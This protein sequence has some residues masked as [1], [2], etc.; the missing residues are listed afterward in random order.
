MAKSPTSGFSLLRTALLGATALV[1]LNPV[2]AEAR[3]GVTSA[4]DG[5]PKG[6]PP[7][8]AERVLRIGIDVQA[9]E[10][11][12]TGAN[13][14]A[15]LVFLDGTALTVGPNARLTVDK[16]V[17]DPATKTGDLA[18]TASK[19]VFRLVG[20]KISKNNPIAITTPSSTIGIRG[21]VVWFSVTDGQ[22]TSNFVFGDKMTVTGQG[23]T[24]TATRPGFQVTSAL[25]LPP[26]TPRV[27]PP[28]GLSA[29][30]G[31]LEGTGS[32]SGG[33]GGDADGGAAGFGAGNSGSGPK[34]AGAP[35]PSMP[36]PSVTKPTDATPPVTPPVPTLVL[37]TRT[38][39]I[40]NSSTGGTDTSLKGFVGGLVEQTVPNQPVSSRILFSG[41]SP[42]DVKIQTNAATNRVE[43]TIVVP[44]LN[45][46]GAILTYQLGGLSN[47]SGVSSLFVDDKTYFAIDQVVD[48]T[49]R[50][51]A[52]VPGNPP[53]QG[54]PFDVDI[55][56]NTAIAS[57]GIFSQAQVFAQ[58][59][60]T[61]CVCDFLTFGSWIGD[62][63]Y[64]PNGSYRPGQIDK[65]DRAT[66]VAGTLS[67]VVA[68]DNLFNQA[69]LPGANQQNFVATYNGHMIGTAQLGNTPSYAAAGTYQ[70]VWSFGA[71][72]GAITGSFDGIAISGTANLINSGPGFVANLNV[73]IAAG[74]GSLNG[75]FFAS[76]TD[77]V[78]GQAG[79]F[80]LAG[81]RPAVANG[82]LLNYQ[83]GGTFAA[84]R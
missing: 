41:G 56:S 83:A 65:L 84:Q 12:T 32:G 40:D 16:F 34:I 68:L 31:S 1:L 61:P 33:S 35:L 50:S 22:T 21:G 66:Y 54:P 64:A 80:L 74:V 44:T 19:G 67:T 72:S 36:P 76:P 45:P 71:R 47:N 73:P 25:G 17:Y 38:N 27:I 5:D 58:A 70:N 78:K 51:K 9:N 69:N 7:S 62:V 15:H 46:G 3:V 11:I 23:V 8:E 13:D 59:G 10:I 39:H 26:G 43:A 63:A 29:T 49:R 4:T 60:V 57:S 6:K 48:P 42:N 30:M 52:T 55:A 28:G 79:S 77:P 14:R 81:Q 82:P 2:L 75:A 53:F 18:I 24:Q 20:G 37:T